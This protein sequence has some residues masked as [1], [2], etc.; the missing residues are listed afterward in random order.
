MEE[1]KNENEKRTDLFMLALKLYTHKMV[2][3]KLKSKFMKEWK[4]LSKKYAKACDMAIE[5]HFTQE[6]SLALVKAFESKRD[7]LFLEF[8]KK[9]LAEIYMKKHREKYEDILFLR[10]LL[11]Y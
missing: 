11:G 6:Q 10:R 9:A 8:I 3:R 2:S 5:L 1:G 4:K 7:K